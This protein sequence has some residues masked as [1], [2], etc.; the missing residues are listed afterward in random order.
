MEL[1]CNCWTPAPEW[2]ERMDSSVSRLVD[3]YSENLITSNGHDT[4][5]IEELDV[6]ELFEQLENEDEGVLREQ[7]LEQLQRE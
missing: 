7:R 6:D 2:F 5:N 1:P 3:A 4:D